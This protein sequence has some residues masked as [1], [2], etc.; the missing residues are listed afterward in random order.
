MRVF[1]WFRNQASVDYN[2]SLI[3]PHYGD[4]FGDFKELPHVDLS[5]TATQHGILNRWAEGDFTTG[6]QK[7]DIHIPS[8]GCCSADKCVVE[9]SA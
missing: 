9:G 6:V 4:L 8:N 5:V 2:P 3:P 7:P 1:K